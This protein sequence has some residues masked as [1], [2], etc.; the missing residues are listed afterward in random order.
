MTTAT[1][2]RSKSKRTHIRPAITSVETRKTDSSQ[3]ANLGQL[4]REPE[5]LEEAKRHQEAPELWQSR[6][7]EAPDA[8][9]GDD[10]WLLENSARGRSRS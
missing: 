6:Q 4:S 10:S 1:R 3:I 8:G 5:P 2:K 9:R 7:D